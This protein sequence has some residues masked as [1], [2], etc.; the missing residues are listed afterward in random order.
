MEL[1]SL[2][3]TLWAKTGTE[4]SASVSYKEAGTKN[5]KTASGY[6]LTLEVGTSRQEVALEHLLWV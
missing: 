5:L 1:H 4:C 3:F 6:V 2:T